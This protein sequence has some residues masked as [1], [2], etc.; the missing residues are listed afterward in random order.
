[1]TIPSTDK[2]LVW[3]GQTRKAMRDF[4]EDVRGVLGYALRVAQQGGKHPDAKPLQGFG[5]AGVL[6]VVDDYDG[7]TYR[8][9]YTVKFAGIVYALHAFQKKSK[10]GSATPQK[11]INLIKT[12]L[13]K[14]AEHYRSVVEGTNA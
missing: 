1:M 7:D 10:T 8:A 3:I 6:E 12:N 13:K 5:G 4:P 14:A 11:E 2:P 9:V